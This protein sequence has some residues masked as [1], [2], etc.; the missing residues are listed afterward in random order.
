MCVFVCVCVFV[1][2]SRVPNRRRNTTY[3]ESKFHTAISAIPS[4]YI[5]VKPNVTQF[6]F[7][8]NVCAKGIG[9]KCCLNQHDR[10]LTRTGPIIGPREQI[11]RKIFDKGAEQYYRPVLVA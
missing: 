9:L 4:Q 11:F 5:I 6:L 2:I 10:M 8:L 1:F 3:S 7:L